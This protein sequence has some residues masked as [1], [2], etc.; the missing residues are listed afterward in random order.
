MSRKQAPAPTL[1]PSA[2][3]GLCGHVGER[4]V[5]VV[6]VEDVRAEVV[7][8]EVRVAVVVVVAD[9]HAQPVARVCRRRP[10][11]SRR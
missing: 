7:Q 2:H 6:A 10:R 11:R 5:A 8:V 1:S 4:A 3:A 9:G